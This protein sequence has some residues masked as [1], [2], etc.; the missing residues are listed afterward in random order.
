MLLIDDDVTVLLLIGFIINLS[1]SFVS[2]PDIADIVND[3]FSIL[4]QI[5]KS[6]KYIA[7][8]TAIPDKIKH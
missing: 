5:I 2:C 1:F 3:K 4:P 8:N 7:A 6:K